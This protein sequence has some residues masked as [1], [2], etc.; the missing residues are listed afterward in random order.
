MVW[1]NNRSAVARG[2][3]TSTFSIWTIA[4]GYDW[5]DL[6]GDNVDAG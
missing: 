5:F 2:H 3:L 4:V 1:E 6:D